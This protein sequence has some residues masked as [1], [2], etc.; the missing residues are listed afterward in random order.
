MISKK[1]ADYRTRVINNIV[2][3]TQSK[4][5]AIFTKHVEAGQGNMEVFVK[6]KAAIKARLAFEKK[7]YYV[8]T[9]KFETLPDC[10]LLLV[11][12]DFSEGL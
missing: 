8:R 9:T 5:L 1:E 12:W 3:N 4:V 11:C 7:G 6:S 2:Y 10:M